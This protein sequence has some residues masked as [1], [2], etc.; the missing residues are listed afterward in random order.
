M[1]QPIQVKSTMVATSSDKGNIALK[2]VGTGPKNAAKGSGMSGGKRS[3]NL[4]PPKT[5]ISSN[6]DGRRSRTSHAVQKETDVTA[7]AR[8]A[9]DKP[10]AT[11][12]KT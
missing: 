6:L 11:G 2:M 10:P 7:G 3:A 4:S 8:S 5:R 12:K 1:N 9:S